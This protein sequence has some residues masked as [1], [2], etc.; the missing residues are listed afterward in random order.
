MFR[1]KE[2]AHIERRTLQ[3]ACI[4]PVLFCSVRSISL[5]SVQVC[6]QTNGVKPKMR[7]H[8][9]RSV[10]N[11]QGVLKEK[12]VNQMGIQRWLVSHKFVN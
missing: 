2:Q 12:G 7:E 9:L 6:S 5:G 11:C 4:L 1:A 8:K 10:V 3:W